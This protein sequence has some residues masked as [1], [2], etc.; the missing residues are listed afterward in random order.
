MEAN[1]HKRPNSKRSSSYRMEVAN[2]KVED[3]ELSMVC[4][5]CN[6]EGREIDLFCKECN[7]DRKEEKEVRVEE[8]MKKES[9]IVKEYSTEMPWYKIDNCES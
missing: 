6:P 1:K 7:E 4:V 3:D 8:K 2:P 9:G 5:D